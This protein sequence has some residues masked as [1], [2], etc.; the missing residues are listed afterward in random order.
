MTPEIY[1]FLEWAS[2]GLILWSFGFTLLTLLGLWL[3]GLIYVARQGIF[4]CLPEDPSLLRN[5]VYFP[6]LRVDGAAGRG[7]EPEPLLSQAH[8]AGKAQD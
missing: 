3:A 6:K 2:P 1:R 4:F 5:M 7:V 8:A